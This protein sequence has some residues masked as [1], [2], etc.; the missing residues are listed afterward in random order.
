MNS[1]YPLLSLETSKLFH[2]C[3]YWNH[4]LRESFSQ[5]VSKPTKPSSALAFPSPRTPKPLMK[6]QVQAIE[7]L[8]SLPKA[9]CRTQALQSPRAKNI[10]YPRT[11]SSLSRTKKLQ[12][13]GTMNHP[14]ITSSSQNPSRL[15]KILCAAFPKKKKKSHNTNPQSPQPPPC[16]RQKI[17][18][19][20]SPTYPNHASILSTKKHPQNSKHPLSTQI[21]S[22]LALPA[23]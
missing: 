22:S 7:A 23:R 20:A 13:E 21:L 17:S 4:V 9:H 16:A 10:Q 12:T 6:V 5:A 1:S 8:P 18:E 2:L 14:P 19:Q 3:L 11:P 15:V